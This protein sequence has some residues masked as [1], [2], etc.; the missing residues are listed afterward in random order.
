[1]GRHLGSGHLAQLGELATS[2]MVIFARGRL[3]LY[4]PAILAVST[5]LSSLGCE[6]TSQIS[7]PWA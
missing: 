4:E 6:K 7:S 3:S 1:M 2:A 5:F